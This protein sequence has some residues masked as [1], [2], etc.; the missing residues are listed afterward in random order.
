MA[1]TLEKVFSNVPLIAEQLN[2]GRLKDAFSD[3]IFLVDDKDGNPFHIKGHK[4][5]MLLR[6]QSEYFKECFKSEEFQNGEVFLRDTDVNSFRL[7]LE[8]IY[9]GNI[10]LTETTLET[11]LEILKLSIC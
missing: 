7:V 11:D 4:T 6:C 2:A 9:A 1:E 10:D 3:V 8:Y 5:I